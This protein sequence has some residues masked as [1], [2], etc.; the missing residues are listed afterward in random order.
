MTYPR[1]GGTRGKRVSQPSA[2]ELMTAIQQSGQF[3]ARQLSGMFK[4]TGPEFKGLPAAQTYGEFDEIIPL[5]GAADTMK[6]YVNDKNKVDYENY[7][8]Q[9]DELEDRSAAPLTLVPTSTTNPERPR[10]VAAG[11]DKHEEK[12]T[13]VFR[14]GTF[15]NYYE[16]DANEWQRFKSVVSKGRFIYAYLDSKPRGEADVS[17]LSPTARK[18]FYR[19]SRAAQ[20]HYTTKSDVFTNTFKPKNKTPK[21]KK[22]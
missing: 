7:G 9:P 2:E 10:T 11:Y 13:V 20:R 18:A 5:F 17:S 16:V 1:G 3:G 15:Y 14:D 6:Y 12:I 22:R 19:F 8:E 4:I 21:P